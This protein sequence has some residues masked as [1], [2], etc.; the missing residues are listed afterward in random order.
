ML[1]YKVLRAGEWAELEAA[2]ETPGAPVDRA[3]GFVHFSTAGAA[4]RDARAATSPARPGSGSSPR[5]RRRRRGAALGAVARRRALPAPLPPARAAPTCSGRGRCRRP[6]GPALRGAAH[7]PRRAARR[8][9]SC[10]GSTPRRRTG[11]RSP[12][13]APGSGRGAGRSTSPRLAD[14][15][16]PGSSC[17]TR[18]GWR[19]ASTRTPRRWRPLRRGRLRLRR[20]RRGDAAAAAGQPAAAALPPGRGPGGRSTASAST[21]TAWR[22]S[23]RGSRRGRRAASSG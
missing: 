23:P 13:C 12:R 2:G 6:D 8:C 19:R 3:D 7:E 5:R 14:A 11:W 21:T 1:I 17:R 20:G 9:R 18:S 10:A 22:R 4:R 16:S 15:R